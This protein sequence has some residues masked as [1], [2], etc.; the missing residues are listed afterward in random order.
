MSSP[1][2]LP[3]A[4]EHID[5]LKT[6]IPYLLPLLPNSLPL[7][8][9][10]Q[11]RPQS[12]HSHIFATFPPSHP[13]PP[14]PPLSSASTTLNLETPPAPPFEFA[15]AWVDRSCA[16]ETECWIFSTWEIRDGHGNFG[17]FPT[18]MGAG[19]DYS[20][21]GKE[22]TGD[23]ITEEARGG[24]L[25]ILNAVAEL[26]YPL[27]AASSLPSRRRVDG[28]L[29]DV[30]GEEK[31]ED[32]NEKKK[33]KEKEKEKDILVIGSLH[34]SILPLLTSPTD[35]FT[36]Q[37][38]LSRSSTGN[39]INIIDPHGRG[40]L[41]RIGEP[42]YKFL[43]PPSL[44]SPFP[45]PSPPPSTSNAGKIPPLLLLP[46]EYTYG[47]LKREEMAI[48]VRRTA[49]PRSV[50]TFS[51]LVNVCIR[52]QHHHHQ[53]EPE[54]HSSREGKEEEEE[55]GPVAWAFLSPDGSL[56]SLHVEPAHR[57]KGL[58]RAVTSKLMDALIRIGEKN[59]EAGRGEGWMSSD[60][61]WDN[62][63]GQGVAKGVGGREGWVCRWVGADL[64]RVREVWG[65][66]G[67]VLR[68]R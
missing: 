35:T 27:T 33:E 62:M 42:T 54:V 18:S 23:G 58:A 44:P 34:S 28:G 6:L 10:I 3:V 48:C 65:K 67:G 66:R 38:V 29:E 20:F 2:T 55:E 16:P 22:G 19:I 68:G 11:H 26:P 49:I 61:Y 52:Y 41:A 53:P 21:M 1:P 15:A 51:E 17:A 7:V 63:G 25:A 4:Y 39:D 14:P 37:R 57:G 13:P 32:D 40:V 9:R 45:S 50:A 8:R 56:S 59:G 46:G 36:A 43:I 64:R 24:L 60:V 5:P 47:T 31:E 12:P 30:A